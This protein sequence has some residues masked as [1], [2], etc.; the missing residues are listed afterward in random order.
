MIALEK[1]KRVLIQIHIIIDY[2]VE[3]LRTINLILLP[4]SFVHPMKQDEQI[5]LNFIYRIDFLGTFYDVFITTQQNV[6]S[7]SLNNQQ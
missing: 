1:L 3:L 6:C 4:N 5:R 7:V 2:I